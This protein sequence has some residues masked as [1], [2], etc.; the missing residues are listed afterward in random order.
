[1]QTMSR[2]IEL[3]EAE[4]LTLEEPSRN[5]PFA[6]FRRR[7]LRV[8]ADILG[9]TEASGCNWEK[10]W[11]TL[12]LTGLLDDW[13]LNHRLVLL[14]LPP[15]SPELNPIEI[16]WKHANTIGAASSPGRGLALRGGSQAYGRRR[17]HL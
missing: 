10:W 3:T 1:M 8:V 7:A 13:L 17:Y 14:Y 2:R 5:H 11:L 4:R 16:V 6:D 9:V 12:R 15:Y